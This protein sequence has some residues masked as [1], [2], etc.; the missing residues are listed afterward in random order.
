[1]RTFR[2]MRTWMSIGL[3]LMAAGL[4]YCAAA[5]SWGV[6]SD[7]TTISI[8]ADIAFGVLL[9]MLGGVV[10]AVVVVVWAVRRM[11]TGSAPRVVSG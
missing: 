11:L 6:T 3:L 1:M 7:D 2:R 4:P 9:A 10:L 8:R 5:F